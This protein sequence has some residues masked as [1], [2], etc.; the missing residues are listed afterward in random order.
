[1]P[2]RDNPRGISIFE[3][4]KKMFRRRQPDDL[5]KLEKA[6]RCFLK[7]SRDAE[8]DSLGEEHRQNRKWNGGFRLATEA[9]LGAKPAMDDF[10]EFHTRMAVHISKVKNVDIAFVLAFND[11]LG[12]APLTREELAELFQ[13]CLDDYQMTY[14]NTPFVAFV[15]DEN[16]FHEL[17]RLHG[18]DYSAM[19]R[20][21]YEGF[22]RASGGRKVL[23][24]RELASA[25]EQAID[26]PSRTTW[27]QLK[28]AILQHGKR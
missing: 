21:V 24:P 7:A 6:Y 19:I 12:Q 17:E 1:M 10:L 11:F 28:A 4:L 25:F 9:I 18:N 13:R 15:T 5:N 8:K 26:A 27:L 16:V 3:N 2:G 20:D 22:G 14:P 23:I